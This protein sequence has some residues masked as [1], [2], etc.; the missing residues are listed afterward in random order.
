MTTEAGKNPSAQQIQ[1]SLRAVSPSERSRRAIQL[2]L[3]LSEQN[4]HQEACDLLDLAWRLGARELGVLIALIVGLKTMER[5]DEILD[6]CREAAFHYSTLNLPEETLFAADMQAEHGITPYDHV[7]YSCL[8]Q[9]FSRHQVAPRQIRK[10]PP[11]KIGYVLWGDN[12]RESSLP[13]LFFRIGKAHNRA[14]FEPIFFSY[15]SPSSLPIDDSSTFVSKIVAHGFELHG[16]STESAEVGK[17]VISLAQE[18]RRREVDIV[19]FQSQLPRYCA[20]ALLRPAPIVAGFDHG[21]PN[22]YSSPALD[23]AFSSVPRYSIEHPCDSILLIPAFLSDPPSDSAA[24]DRETIN[25][26]EEAQLIVT[27]GFQAKFDEKIAGV[28]DFFSVVGKILEENTTLHW[29][30][31]GVTEDEIQHLLR[32]LSSSVRERVRC[33]GIVPDINPY[34]KIATVYLDT[35]P[36][37]GGLAV[38]QAMALEVPTFTYRLP[39]EG[40]FNKLS[41][42]S[43]VGDLIPE[44]S[45]LMTEGNVEAIGAMLRRTLVEPNLRM[46]LVME[47]KLLADRL[48][49]HKRFLADLEARYLEI[50]T[51]AQEGATF[52]K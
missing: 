19:V 6:R 38:H 14:I 27:S 46:Q 23:Y 35:F 7:I 31:V 21:D 33:I 2:F 32:L 5:T 40:K 10:E 1:D 50:I 44:R 17:R 13:G 9:V 29:C 3:V 47:G 51:A 26:P 25:V 11:Y 4:R 30:I 39:F 36:I 37:A 42:Y 18:I 48:G 15:H 52:G 45:L 49:D 16:N 41:K 22:V 34:L 8:E 24:I 20:T 43:V 28:F 12:Q